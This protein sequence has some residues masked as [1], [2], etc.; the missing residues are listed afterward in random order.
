MLYK[1]EP[2]IYYMWNTLLAFNLIFPYFQLRFSF[3]LE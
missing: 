1:E 3:S 2:L